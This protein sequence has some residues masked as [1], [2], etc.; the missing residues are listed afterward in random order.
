[1][2]ATITKKL[3]VLILA[4]VLLIGTFVFV[5]QSALADQFK[6]LTMEF[7]ADRSGSDYRD[8]VQT[9]NNPLNCQVSCAQDTA[10]KAY[11]FVPAGILTFEPRGPVARCYLKNSRPQPTRYKGLISGAKLP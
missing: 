5:P 4:V 3:N 2:K 10:C 9:D 1:M 7:G 11:T 8:T 6:S